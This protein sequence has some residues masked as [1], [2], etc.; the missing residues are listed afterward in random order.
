MKLRYETSITTFIQLVVVSLFIIASG[1]IDTLKECQEHGASSCV[2]SSFLWIVIL[3]LVGGFFV[4]VCAIGYLAQTKRSRRLAKLLIVAE[5]GIAL[6]SFKLLTTPSSWLGG[7][8]SLIIFG[9]ALWTIVL[10]YRLVK[11]KGGRVVVKSRIQKT[12]PRRRL[13]EK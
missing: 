5:A 9:L 11:A 1:V 13:S 7:I 10:A 3:F 2:A 4:S 6:V 12:R 8:G